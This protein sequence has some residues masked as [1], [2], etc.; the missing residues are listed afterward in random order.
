MCLGKQTS[1]QGAKVSI[2]EV[3]GDTAGRVGLGPNLGPLKI[4][5]SSDSILR[6]WDALISV[7][8]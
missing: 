6:H 2:R 1:F 5:Q 3:V 4:K 8:I 7:L